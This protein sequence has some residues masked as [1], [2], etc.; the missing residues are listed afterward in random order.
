MGFL[1]N[2]RWDFSLISGGGKIPPYR[3]SRN[4]DYEFPSFPLP[5]NF[6]ALPEPAPSS[7]SGLPE[8]G[9]SNRKKLF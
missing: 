9:I 7:D 5:V 1:L 8:S 6:E 4:E 3:N 2:F